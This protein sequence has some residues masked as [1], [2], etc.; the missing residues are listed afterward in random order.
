MKISNGGKEALIQAN[1]NKRILAQTGVSPRS[2]VR[3]QIA[4]FANTYRKHLR[5]RAGVELL[6]TALSRENLPTVIQREGKTKIKEISPINKK[7][8]QQEKVKTEDE[9]CQPKEQI[10]HEETVPINNEIR[11]GE[12]IK[13]Q[14]R[15]LRKVRPKPQMKKRDT[16]TATAT[17]C[18][19]Q[20][21]EQTTSHRNHHDK[22]ANKQ[23]QNILTS[24]AADSFKKSVCTPGVRTIQQLREARSAVS[25]QSV[26][27]LAVKVS[28]KSRSTLV[29]DNNSFYTVVC[30]KRRN[31]IPYSCY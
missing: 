31:L 2:L 4:Q 10:A 18:S 9:I 8:L 27:E 28:P 6:Q 11:N 30:R 20:I 22:K 5:S 29:C 16:Q 24:A 15:Q 17:N 1:Q 21:Q 19:K 12:Q 26:K 13:D 3:T 23:A 7:T 14:S 25:T